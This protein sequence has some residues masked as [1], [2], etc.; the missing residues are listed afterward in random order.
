MLPD[1][2]LIVISSDDENEMVG[3]KPAPR[4]VQPMVPTTGPLSL[5]GASAAIRASPASPTPQS[6]LEM[7]HT[8]LTRL[9][10]MQLPTSYFSEDD[11]MAEWTL[12]PADM[13]N[14]VQGPCPWEEPSKLTFDPADQEDAL[15]TLVRLD[16]YQASMERYMH[17]LFNAA[18]DSPVI[19]NR[20]AQRPATAGVAAATTMVGLKPGEMSKDQIVQR[21]AKQRGAHPQVLPYIPRAVWHGSNWEDWAQFNNKSVIHVPFSAHEDTFLQRRVADNIAKRHASSAQSTIQDAAFWTSVAA[22]LPGRDSKDCLYRYLDL[23]DASYPELFTKTLILDYRPRHREPDRSMYNW[24]LHRSLTAHTSQTRSYRDAVW[25]NLSRETTIGEGSGDALCL[26]IAPKEDKSGF[27]VISGSLCQEEV[28]YNIEGNLRLW[29]SSNQEV[30]QLR[31]HCTESPMPDGSSQVIW[32]TVEDVKALNDRLLVSVGRDGTARVWDMNE[33]TL[34]STLQCHGGPIHQVA[35]SSFHERVFATCSDDGLGSVWQIGENGAKGQGVVCESSHPKAGLGIAECV[36]FGRES[37]AFELYTGYRSK[38]HGPGWIQITDV[39][40]GLPIF[41]I[42]DIGG[43]CGCLAV[44][45]SGKFILSGNDDC[46][47]PYSSRPS[48]DQMMHLHDAKT[49]SSVL[50]AKTGHLD[51]NC[52]TFSACDTY[53]ASGSESNQI[54]IFDVRKAHRPLYEFAHKGKK[55]RVRVEMEPF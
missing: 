25:T 24:T 12:I 42:N 7:P 53:I 4:L 38:Q 50:R 54:S 30:H 44:S 27:N 1:R 52:V 5:P 35:V 20:K 14:H 26:T 11:L 55:S 33:K 49:G 13:D 28:S 34:Q 46:G 19:P 51:V 17:S 41:V 18:S 40:S 36:E 31:A 43:A 16:L 2:D 6:A 29:D 48:G 3:L 47:N 23:Q 15:D 22:K 37:S 32:H 45:H 8:L 39:V 10:D 9:N 21:V